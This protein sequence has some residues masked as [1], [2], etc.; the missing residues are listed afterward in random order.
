MVARPG[1][2]QASNNAGEMAPT[3]HGRTDIKQFYSGLAYMRNFEPVPQGGSRLSPRTRHVGRIRNKLALLTS[4]GS[5]VFTGPFTG[6]AILATL[7]FATPQNVTVVSIPASK[8]SQRLVA[9]LQVEWLDGGTWSPFGDPFLMGTTQADRRVALPPRSF[10]TTFSIRLRMVSA[11]PSST[12]FTL[13]PLVAYAETSTLPNAKL[14]PFTFS[15]NQSY[16][17][18]LIEG[19]ADFYRDTA[20]VG[21]AGN[22]LLES[23]LPGI[24]VVQ[25]LDTMQLYH[26]DVRP[27]R[28][29]RDGADNAWIT[30]RVPAAHI[31]NVDLG[32]SYTNQVTDIWHVYL[33]FPSSGDHSNG[34]D[35]TVT[36]NVNGEQTP[37]INTGSP[38]DWS[39]FLTALQNAIIDLDS[40]EPGISVTSPGSTTTSREIHIVFSGSENNGGRNVVSAAVVNTTDG[41]A[42]VNHQQTGKPGGEPLFSTSAGWPSC[43]NFY[44]DRLITGGFR[45][46]KGAL[47]ASVTADYYNNS[48]DLVAV[49]GAILA[50]IDTEGSET[51][52]RIAISRHLVLF[53]S[54]AEYFISDRALSK[55]TPPTI[56]NCSR[57]GSAPGIPICENEGSLYYM[58]RNNALLYAATYDDVSQAY[59]SQPMS[60]LA[61][62]IVNDAVDMAFQRPATAS[63]AGRLWLP[64]AD[65]T[66]TVG[67]ILRNQ[68]VTAFARWETSG[69]VTSV[70]V[71][72]KNDT[73]MLVE[74]VVDGT[75]ELH[76]EKLELGLIFDDT[77]AQTFEPATTAIT[78][79]DIHE[80]VE[81]WALAD[82]YVEGPFT[83][84]GG[85]IALPHAS[86]DVQVGR[87]TAPRALT[88]PLPSEVADKVVL[89]RP[90]RVHTVRLDLVDATSLAVGANGRPA[91]N[92]ALALS[93]EAADV[94][95][96]PVNRTQAISGLVGFSDDGQVEITQVR[97]GQLAW[98]GITIEART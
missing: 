64:R 74:R 80:G 10:V 47:L 5:A 13:S 39:A 83:V 38:P 44:Q 90:K 52:Q 26:P 57:N 76:L 55:A 20:F 60:L 84:T 40:V 67:I 2:Y 95:Q 97:P 98:R 19:H 58:S 78:G 45:S 96:P 56:V 91:R 75:M 69:D 66:V 59:P 18:V 82:G 31:P 68:D 43:G 50:N 35:L 93:G 89:R 7:T 72:G 34:A 11:P 36:L 12:T 77:V 8:S 16:T 21:S 32:G 86:S 62:H 92:V 73:F 22:N 3:A 48:V 30:D 85:Q 1:S 6:A 41:A 9:I 46:K 70:C 94:P 79:L 88:L 4:S 24:D 28:I 81:V 61:S 49:N 65:G 87:W 27:V 71:D 25:R 17:V 23:Q 37:G 42:T 53:T 33:T 54:N 14:R 63:D 29:F 15:L 51:L